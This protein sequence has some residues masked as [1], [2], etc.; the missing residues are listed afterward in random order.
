MLQLKNYQE[1]ALDSLRKYLRSCDELQDSDAAFYQTTRQIWERGIPYNPINE[2]SELKDIP[3][4]CL[5]LPT[6]GGKTLL[7]CHAVHVANRE[8]LKR[9]RSLVLW[10]VPSNTIREQTV[11][12][13]KDRCHPYRQA[14]ES[15]LGPVTAMR[16]EEALYLQQASLL[17]STVII[18]S[19]L[20]AFRVEDTEGRRV[21]AS[22]GALL[23]HFQSLAPEVTDKLERDTQGN[24]PHSLANVLRI[25]RP[26][27]IVDEAHN[28]RTALSFDTLARFRPAAILEFT[29]TPDTGEKS[30]TPSNILH[31]VSAAELK[32]E[33]MIKLPIRLETNPEWQAILADAIVQ[34]Q[35]LD[36]KALLDHQQTGQYIRPIMLIQAQPRHKKMDTLTV[37]VVR[38]ALIEDHHIPEEQIARATGEDKELEDVDIWNEKCPI[39]YIITVYALK[40]GWDCSFAY[41]LC[42]LAAMHKSS[43]VEQILG[44]VLRLPYNRPRGAP[45]LNRA[46]AFVTSRDFGEA[47]QSLVD[48]LVDNGFNRQEAA[49]FIRPMQ[50]DQSPLPLGRQ[51]KQVP[52][53]QVKLPEVPDPAKLPLAIREKID[54]DAEK[55]TITI[56]AFLYPA[57][58]TT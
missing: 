31:S 12:A 25:N 20:Q 22:D 41:V 33:D 3:Y 53:R 32:A 36:R 56:N 17:G 34:L 15:T 49:E 9:D 30:K 55:R 46:Y 48:A 45:E 2:P 42:S 24:I 28:A 38:K 10:L 44:R 35:D 43:A 29:A 40:E 26:L 54:V 19:T 11:N 51:R 13:L 57:E 47:A 7:A 4:V 5:R 8:Y 18:V 50:A 27:V 37:E 6:G 21:Y 39:R 58:E 14:L 16:I 23:H 1:K 52:P